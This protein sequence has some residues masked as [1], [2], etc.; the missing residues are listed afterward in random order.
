MMEY[1]V[2]AE[3]EEVEEYYENRILESGLDITGSPEDSVLVSV[4]GDGSIMYNVSV[5]DGMDAVLPVRHGGSAG[6]RCTVDEIEFEDALEALER[7]DYRCNSRRKLSAFNEDGEELTEDFSAIG[8]IGLHHTRPN[9]SAMYSF[10]IEDPELEFSYSGEGVQG[11]GIVVS[12]PFGST[13]YF[14]TIT[15]GSSFEEGIGVALNNI[16]QDPGT[17]GFSLS[18]SAEV[19]LRLPEKEH[20]S[21]ARLFPDIAREEADML[22]D[23]YEPEIG[24]EVTVRLTDR[25]VDLLEPDI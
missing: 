1:F 24:E 14:Q 4:G 17:K 3:R 19:K 6:N 15:G 10:E 11:D 5:Y 7:G 20:H 12:T 22:R 18:E 2:S 8:E 25:T 16:I 9:S 23:P 13:G 21:P